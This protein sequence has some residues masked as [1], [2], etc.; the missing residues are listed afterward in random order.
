MEKLIMNHTP[1]LSTVKIQ[2]GREVHQQAKHFSQH[3]S[4][5]YNAQQIYL[6]TLA[7]YAVNEYLKHQKIKTNLGASNS[8]DIVMQSLMDIADL[9]VNG[10]GKL[11]CRSVL[12]DT[13]IVYIPA[14]V[15]ED[16]IAYVVVQMNESLTE[17]T[18]L[19]FAQKVT[20]EEFPISQLQ[21][22]EGLVKHLKHQTKPLVNLSEWFQNIVDTGWQTIEELLGTPELSLAFR[23]ASS[24]RVQRAKIVELPKQG[25]GC[26]VALVLDL[27]HETEGTTRIRVQVRSF[28]EEIVLPDNLRLLVLDEEGKMFIEVSATHSDRLI[29]T[30]LFRGQPGE[31]F[32]VKVVLGEESVTEKFLI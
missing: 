13:E 3:Q 9:D 5:F 16:R 24:I 26:V 15:W 2:L 28:N 12:Q 1:Q 8:W 18:L 14:E 22:L 23:D 30:K 29:Q 10:I 20:T 7:V 21:P 19:G 31:K 32:T 6:N 4:N 25:V 27:T 17:A 11:E